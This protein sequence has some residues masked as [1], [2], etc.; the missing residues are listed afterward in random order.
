MFGMDNPLIVSLVSYDTRDECISICTTLN[1]ATNEYYFKPI[2]IADELH[3]CLEIRLKDS[4][5]GIVAML[6]RLN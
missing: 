3:P 4:H 5:S 6:N 2:L 1:E